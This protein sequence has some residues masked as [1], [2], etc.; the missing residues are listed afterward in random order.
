[1]N[2]NKVVNGYE[3]KLGADLR[4]ADLNGTNLRDANLTGAD[5]YGSNQNL[6]IGLNKVAS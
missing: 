2:V 5:L 6:A 4:Y 1:M 3:I